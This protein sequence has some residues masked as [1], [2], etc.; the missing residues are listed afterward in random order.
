MGHVFSLPSYVA[1][2]IPGSAQYQEALSLLHDGFGRLVRS[3]ALHGAAIHGS[4]IDACEPGSDVDV[5]VMANSPRAFDELRALRSEVEERTGVPLDFVPLLRAEAEAGRHTIDQ[6]YHAFL[7]A[8]GKKAVIGADPIGSIGPKLSWRDPR[9]EVREK[10]V[11]Q[12]KKLDKDR[13]SIDPDYGERH[14]RFLEHLLRQ[15]IYAA[16]DTLR[17]R[18]GAYPTES[19]R[20]LSKA[21]CCALLAEELPELATSELARVLEARHEY[22]GFLRNGHDVVAYRDLLK[23]VDGVYPAARAVLAQQLEHASGV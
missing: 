17:L 9:R 16:I 22:R 7:S 5:L 6:F 3:R 15:P 8:H 12:A 20:P 21:E 23:A 4:S 11:A 19:G 1:G 18:H 14:C 13:I 2:R 10:L